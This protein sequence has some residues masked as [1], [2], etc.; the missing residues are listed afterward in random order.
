[1]IIPTATDISAEEKR[2]KINAVVIGCDFKR[3]Q[4]SDIF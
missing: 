1:V 2:K 3:K 4:E